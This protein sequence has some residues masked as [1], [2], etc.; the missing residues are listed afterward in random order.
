MLIVAFLALTKVPTQ[1]P[2]LNLW[3]SILAIANLI[4]LM[5]LEYCKWK[6]TDM[7]Q[8]V[9]SETWI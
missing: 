7:L 4:Y 2:S 6:F 3:V 9:W 5:F 8:N 1:Q